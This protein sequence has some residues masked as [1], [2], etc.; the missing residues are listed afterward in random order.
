MDTRQLPILFI[1]DWPYD[2]KHKK[3]VFIHLNHLIILSQNTQLEGRWDSLTD[4]I[5]CHSSVDGVGAVKIH[6]LV[7]LGTVNGHTILL[8]SAVIRLSIHPVGVGEG[9]TTTRVMR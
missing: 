3:T 9:L 1:L 4:S 5:V 7:V 2:V 6:P 8:S